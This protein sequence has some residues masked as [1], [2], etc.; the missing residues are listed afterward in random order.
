MN[1]QPEL[2]VL[3]YN[4]KHRKT[5]DVLCMLKA[6]GY[7]HVSVYAK[8]LHYV[9]QFKPLLEH[10]PPVYS[11]M[12]DTPTVC[13]NFRFKYIDLGDSD[14]CVSEK[15]VLI[16]GAGILSDDFVQT[17][18]IINSHPGYIPNCRGLDAY[19]WAIYENQP[20]GVTSHI[21]GKYVDAG[22]VIER[23]MIDV[24]SG[25][26]F[27]YVAQKVYDA[28]VEMLVNA[29]SKLDQDHMFIYPDDFLVHKRM[30]HEKEK[31]L[32]EKFEERK[33]QK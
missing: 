23:R 33:Q 32:L 6:K 7:D 17:H 27:Y 2:A 16:C 15:I 29:I 26:T 14:I 19:K 12:P 24:S 11:G 4:V 31:T 21:L 22:E 8:S 18:T 10:R 28:E 13:K 5:Y 1:G 20:I 30:S 25:D 9:K 3:T